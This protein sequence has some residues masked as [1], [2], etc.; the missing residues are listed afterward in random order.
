MRVN[1]ICVII[2]LLIVG[3]LVFALVRGKKK[4]GSCGGNC[5]GCAGCASCHHTGESKK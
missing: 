4:G 5:A 1:V 2:T 3:G